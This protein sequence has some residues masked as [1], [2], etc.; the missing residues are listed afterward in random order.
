[1]SNLKRRRA[2]SAFGVLAIAATGAAWS[3][4]G[5]DD[6]DEAIDNAQEQID[7]ATDEA[8]E[9][10]NETAEEIQGEVDDAVN[11]ATDSA[12][13]AADAA[14]SGDTEAAEDAANER[15]SG[16]RGRE[17]GRRSGSGS[18]RRGSAVRT[19]P[20][21]AGARISTSR[22]SPPACRRRTV[23]TDRARSSAGSSAATSGHSMNAIASSV[24]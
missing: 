7:E 9:N 19:H 5:D 20:G 3:G 21:G 18:N 23:H 11:D 12:Q 4:C 15:R 1:M 24:R 17:R 2:M 14:E 16:H 10:A 22:R 13:E 6:A 8:L